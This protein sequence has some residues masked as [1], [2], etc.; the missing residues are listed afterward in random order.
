MLYQSLIR[1]LAPLI[2]LWLGLEAYLRQGGWR[3]IQQRLGFN[4]SLGSRKGIWLHCASVGEVKAIE[5]L[6]RSRPQQTWLLTTNTP[7]G[8]RIAQALQADMGESLTLAYLPIDWPFAIRRF[9]R[10]YQPAQ[11]WVVETE[12][13]PNLYRVCAQADIPITL[14]NARLSRKTLQAPQWLKKQYQN[15][16]HHVSKI[17]ARSQAEA[18]RFIALGAEAEKI[19]ILGNLKLAGLN[20]LAVP[21]R[22]IER[23]YVLLASS[24]HD[25]ELQIAQ[26]WQQSLEQPLERSE[27]LVIVPRHPKR[28]IKIQAQLKAVAIRAELA[29]Q[30][31]LTAGTRVWIQDSFGELMPLYAHAKLVI[32]G[33]S[34][35]PKGGHNFLEPAAFA[36]AIITGADNSD[37]AD[38]L[39]I[40][41]QQDAIR[42]AADYSALQSEISH[43]LDDDDLRQQLGHRAQ[44]TLQQQPNRLTLYQQALGL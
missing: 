38:E 26:I 20:E 42:V 35:V 3:F 1:L 10:H 5:A 43:L 4:Y 14:I 25:E 19:S 29:S 41:Q 16:L 31:T 11:L 44:Q 27:L 39:A 40:F 28:A 8:F 33:G 37:F 2:L 7:T 21:S 12:L 34:F 32:M 9:I 30:S 17:L 13:W 22:V 6:I 15:C 36:R 24:H 18:Q 23:D